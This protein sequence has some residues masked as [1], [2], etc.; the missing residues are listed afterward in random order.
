MS[1]PGLRWLLIVEEERV[2]HYRSPWLVDDER[3]Y[4]LQLLV[5]GEWVDV[6]CI[7]PRDRPR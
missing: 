2:E 4:V 1:A 5:D 7:D 3:H 6:P